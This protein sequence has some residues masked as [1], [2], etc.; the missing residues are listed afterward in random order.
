MA[1][2]MLTKIA[3][4]ST[5]CG[6]AMG[7]SLVSLSGCGGDGQ[8][9][10]VADPD[11]TGDGDSTTSD[12]TTS[13][14]TTG[15][16]DGDPVA[17]L[18]YWKD[19]KPILDQYCVTCHLAGGI[20]PFAL[21]TWAQ[22]QELAPILPPSIGDLTMPPWPP[23]PDCNSFE[24]DRSLPVEA[25]ELLLAWID[26]G[27]PEGDIADAPPDP[28][29][30]EPFVPDFMLTIPE[31]YTPSATPDDYR[32]F[33][34]PWP[35]ELTEPV[36]V[37]GQVVYPDQLE[38]VHHVISFVADEDEAEF[39]HDLDAAEPGPGYECFGGPGKLDWTARWLGDWVPGMDAWRAPEGTGIEVKPGSWL[40]VQVHYSTIGQDLGPD[41]TTLGFQITD[42]VERPGT[43]VPVTD[44]RWP[45][46][47]APMT[48]PAGDPN[49]HHSAT[50]PRNG[51]LFQF[52]LGVLGVGPN[53]EIDIWRSA[54]HMH[55]IGT[56]A[57]L[58]ILPSE[59][60]EDC[61]LQVDDWDF[62]WQ[63]DY[64]FQQPR[65]FGAG[66]TMQLDC[67]YDNTEAN[68][69]MVNGR[70]KQPETI[71]WGDGTYDEMCLGVVYAARK[72]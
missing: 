5:W 69:P 70:P 7:L 18:T 35:E 55:L 12:S 53:E 36:F 61:L 20:G 27:Y 51:E 17:A 64:M 42:A 58:S 68:Q 71:G 62:N 72:L 44:Y 46:G 33:M 4:L 25:R 40:I 34:V 21:E 60:G 29:P 14:S 66:D 6:L 45:F 26:A 41:Q 1:C 47:I 56:H 13:D 24:E 65:S 19:A 49:V 11:T 63:G 31:V 54:L 22:V 15:D 8:G 23:N 16:G 10:E 39:Y 59:G 48:I 52:T 2:Q 28:T 30:P 50:L 38:L 9:N 67:W 3:Q 43:F 37:T 57:K 32:C